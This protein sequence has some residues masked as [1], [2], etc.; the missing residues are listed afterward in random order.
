MRERL[1]HQPQFQ[2]PPRMLRF[3]PSPMVLREPLHSNGFRHTLP[4][5]VEPG[6]FRLGSDCSIQL[7]YGSFRKDNS[8]SGCPVRCDLR[9]TGHRAE[10]KVIQETREMS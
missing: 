1:A 4:P 7:S 5:G 10:A 2:T 6:T 3:Q 8:G 9:C